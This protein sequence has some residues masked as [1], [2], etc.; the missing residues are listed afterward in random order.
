MDSIYGGGKKTNNGYGNSSNELYNNINGESSSV[1]STYASDTSSSYGSNSNSNKHGSRAF[2]DK[3]RFIEVW[4][5][6][7]GTSFRGFIADKELPRGNV[8]QTLFLF[9][10]HVAGTQLKHGYG[11]F[12]Y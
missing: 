10:R 9:F 5:Y 4:D 12:F 6:V 7:G 1:D 3:T 11:F 8:E 2:K